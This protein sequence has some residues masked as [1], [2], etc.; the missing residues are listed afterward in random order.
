MYQK[1]TDEKINEL[2]ETGIAEFAQNGRERANI[3][4]YREKYN[5]KINPSETKLDV[6]KTM[7]DELRHSQHGIV[8]FQ[9]DS[10]ARVEKIQELIG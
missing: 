7:Y 8:A 9:E 4:D 6:A 3:N 5:S 2:L 1:L 10:Q